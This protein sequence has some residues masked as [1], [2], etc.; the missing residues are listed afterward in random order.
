MLDLYGLPIDSPLSVVCV[1]VFGHITNAFEHMDN[2]QRNKDEFI[3]KTAVV[4]DTNLAAHVAK[5]FHQ[6]DQEP[7]KQIIDPLN[8]QLGLFRILRTSPLTEVPFI[9]CTE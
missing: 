6:K 8:S 1:E 2:L 3:E 5:S 7:A 4:F 9:C